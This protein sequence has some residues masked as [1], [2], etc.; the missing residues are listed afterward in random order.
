MKSLLLA[1]KKRFTMYVI[2][3]LMT[4]ISNLVITFAMSKAFELLEVTA[5]DERVRI[6]VIVFLMF[7]FPPVSFYISRQLRVGFMR[8]ILVQVRKQS[9]EKIMNLDV[10]DYKTTPKEVYLSQMVSDLNLFEKD[11]FLSVLNMVSSGGGFVLGVIV[12]WWMVSPWIAVSTII[13]ALVLYGVAH[14]FEKPVREAALNNQKANVEYN[15]ELSNVLNGLEVTKLYHVETYF[16]K[17][18]QGIIHTVERIKNRYQ[19]LNENQ[20]AITEG[21]AS[22]YQLVML[23]FAT[24]L[25]ATDQIGMSAMILV[26]NLMGSMV[27]GFISF[28]SFI[29][30]FKSSMDVYK[31]LTQLNERQKSEQQMLNGFNHLEVNQLSYAYGDNQVLHNIAFAI[32][33]KSKVLIYGPSGVGKTTLL[34][35]LTQTLGG[36]QGSI[37]MND[38]EL[39]EIDNRSFLSTCGYVRQSHFMFDQSIKDNI[40]LNQPYD[41]ARLIQVLKDVDLWEWIT[42]LEAGVDHPLLANGSNISGGQKQR[43]SIARE[44]Y[45]ECEVLFVDEPSASLDDQTSKNIYETLV[46]LDRTIICVSHRHLNYLKQQFNTV[47]ELKGE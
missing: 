13:F 20:Q 34:N 38:H 29:N 42:T 35:C 31:R 4:T 12:L 8:D 37:T 10:Q 47:I 30:R 18:A 44:L 3:A 21:L 19:R 15:L 9:F 26:Y 40:I 41:E 27:W 33:P 6:V 1:N 28:T 16:L 25:W 5:F 24:Y 14:Y 43:V 2:G 11:F 17:M 32:K 36:Y 23:I 7:M 45:R 46:K 22:S 39:N